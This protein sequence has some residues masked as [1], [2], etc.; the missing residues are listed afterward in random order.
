MANFAY[1]PQHRVILTR[2]DPTAR[3]GRAAYRLQTM[4]QATALLPTSGTVGQMDITFADPGQVLR[5][6]LSDPGTAPSGP[7]PHAMD[8]V[9]LWLTNRYGQWGPAWTGYVDEA[10]YIFDPDRGE[11]CHLLCSSPYKR[12]EMTHVSPSDSGVLALLYS[13]N[14]AASSVLT[15]S[16]ARVGFPT[17]PPMLQI[18]PAAD[19]GPGF[20]TS[21][22]QS[23]FTTPDESSW[24]AILQNLQA[25]A[26]IEFY[27][28]A[29]GQGIWRTVGF[30]LGPGVQPRPVSPDDILHM[31]LAESDRGIVTSIEVRWAYCYTVAQAGAWP[32]LP[33][34]A[35]A[36]SPMVTQLGER[37]LV[38]YA[39]WITTRAGAQHLAEVLGLQYSAG[40]LQGSVTL[41]A[42]PLYGPGTLCRVPTLYRGQPD[43]TT[44]YYVASVSYTLVW[45]QQWVMT[46]GLQYGRS[47]GQSFPYVGTVRAYPTA[48]TPSSTR[49]FSLAEMTALSFAPD[50][51]ATIQNSFTVVADAT[52]TAQQVRVDETL[53]PVGSLLQIDDPTTHHPLGQGNGEYTAVA[54]QSGYTLGL[55]GTSAAASQ[56]T[57]ISV[58]VL[59][60]P[61]QLGTSGLLTQGSTPGTTNAG[62]GGTVPSGGASR[63]PPAPLPGEL[64]AA[65]STFALRALQ[66]ALSVQGHPYRPYATGPDAFD[67][68]GLV[69]WA[70]RVAGYE[71]SQS[72][73]IDSGPGGEY[74]W[75]LGHGA[76]KIAVADARPGDLLFSQ[77]PGCQT[78]PDGFGHV[79][80]L[81]STGPGG[82]DAQTF[83]ALSTTYGVAFFPV[84]GFTDF[85]TT[86]FNLALDMSGVTPTS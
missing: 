52:M 68:S 33:P 24:S 6:P 2:K 54:G 21:L 48:T 5:G 1:A 77:A 58:G 9:Q 75:F 50:A 17:T 22:I 23:A 71:T 80:F 49:T 26:G 25:S 81:Y 8:V 86:P 85:C 10:H 7:T 28:N 56:V 67:C 42:D 18:D 74:R 72:K 73:W 62:N 47:R 57:I 76:Q 11:L 30:L 4:I 45:G 32:T 53:I 66:V 38:V 78:N 29:L 40:L 35:A 64:A 59:D 14:V 31:D 36:P 63:T 3:S 15:L 13:Q 43:A 70:Y 55:R 65:P 20:T 61:V 37:H 82:K 12:W 34:A 39:P 44:D 16:A 69:Y 41:P 51:P 79:A 60:S 27:F 84:A 19:S 83:S 46:L